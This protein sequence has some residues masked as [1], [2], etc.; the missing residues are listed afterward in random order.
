MR[1]LNAKAR[2][3]AHSSFSKK[4][5]KVIENAEDKLRKTDENVIFGDNT[6]IK[7][8]L[9]FEITQ[10]MQEVLKEMYDYWLDY[11]KRENFSNR[12]N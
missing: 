9:G 7:R 4:S 6:K 3:S 10:S 12:I 2:L 1:I 5:I 8:E 11:Y